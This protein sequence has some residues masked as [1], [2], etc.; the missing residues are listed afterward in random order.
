M[1]LSP[2][3]A[4]V[5]EPHGEEDAWQHEEGGGGAGQDGGGGA[6]E[7][8]LLQHASPR[9]HE[10]G[11]GVIQDCVDAACLEGGGGGF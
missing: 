11:W 3:P 1:C 7:P 8:Q 6:T 5:H 10:D 2:P 4:P 9:V